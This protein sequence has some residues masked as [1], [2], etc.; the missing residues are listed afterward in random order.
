MR[1]TSARRQTFDG[2]PFKIIASYNQFAEAGLYY[3]GIGDKTKCFHCNGGLE[4]WELT[5]D[6]MLE[7]AKWY[8]GCEFVLQKQGADFMTSVSEQF[9]HFDTPVIRSSF[10]SMTGGL[11]TISN[12]EIISNGVPIVVTRNAAAHDIPPTHLQRVTTDEKVTRE[13]YHSLTKLMLN[14]GCTEDVLKKVLKKRLRDSDMFETASEFM[15]AIHLMESEERQREENNQSR[16]ATEQPSAVQEQAETNTAQ[17]ASSSTE[18][19]V[20]IRIREL[21]QTHRCKVCLDKETACVFQPCGHLC[22]CLDCAEL[23]SSCPICRKPI[24]RILRINCD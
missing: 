21:Q 3:T 2:S 22:A 19:S 5:D 14:F 20:E 13:M 24:T 4:K 10:S 1:S 6:P 18:R 11:I 9:Q 7:H 16:P 17:A 8:P 12:N 15:D 23:L